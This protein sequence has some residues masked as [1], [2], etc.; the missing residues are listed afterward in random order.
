MSFIN[1]QNNDDFTFPKNSAKIFVI[2]IF[3]IFSQPIK[4]QQ[5]Q[6]K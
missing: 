5:C 1:R 2:Q 4:N 6:Q 3:F